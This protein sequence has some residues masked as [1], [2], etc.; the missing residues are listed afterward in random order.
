LPVGLASLRIPSAR[1]YP[2][3][4]LGRDAIPL[5]RERVIGVAA[6]NLVDESQIRLGILGQSGRRGENRDDRIAVQTPERLE[7][8]DNRRNVDLQRPE[9]LLRSERIGALHGVP[10]RFHCL[11]DVIGDISAPDAG[12]SAGETPGN[13]RA[14]TLK[15]G[16]EDLGCILD[17]RKYDM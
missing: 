14:S 7:A 17:T 2:L 9:G 3:D 4:Q 13:D 12:K 1:A 5:D 11:D 16:A 8:A 15:Q 6:I 10:G